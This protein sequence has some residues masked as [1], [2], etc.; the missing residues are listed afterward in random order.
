MVFGAEVGRL[1][2]VCGDH[3]QTLALHRAVQQLALGRDGG[4]A[5]LPVA[6]GLARRVL[7]HLADQR[8]IEKVLLRVGLVV[9][10]QPFQKLHHVVLF[11]EAQRIGLEQVL[12]IQA[13]VRNAQPVFDVKP[14]VLA[15]RQQVVQAVHVLA[16][17]GAAN[18]HAFDQR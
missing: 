1:A 9:G 10:Y 11:L 6:A 8:A 12:G 3:A 4:A 17:D 7:D 13:L 14:L 2:V 18:A 5:V 16:N 15:V